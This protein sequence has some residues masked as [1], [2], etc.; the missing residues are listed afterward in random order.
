MSSAHGTFSTIDPILGHKS[1][2]NKDKK[3]EILS[4]IFSD[5]NAMK[6]E[7]TTRNNVDMEQIL[8][9]ERTPYLRVNGLTEKLKRKLNS[10]WKPRKTGTPQAKTSGMQQRGSFDGSL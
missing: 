5:H 8:G 9:D 3:I 6:L 7:I 4:C 2:L 10:P 1:A